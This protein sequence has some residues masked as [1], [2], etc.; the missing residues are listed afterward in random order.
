[1][2]ANTSYRE[3]SCTV[4][5]D[6]MCLKSVI[7]FFKLIQIRTRK[8][9]KIFTFSNPILEEGEKVCRA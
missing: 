6:I 3:P 9:D 7:L 8:F 1:M 2:R 5:G 4:I